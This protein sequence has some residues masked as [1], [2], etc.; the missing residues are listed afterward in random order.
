[1]AEDKAFVCPLVRVS[2]KGEPMITNTQAQELKHLTTTIHL[3]I[4]RE[5]GT[6]PDHAHGMAL[7]ALHEM[8]CS[9]VNGE[10]V[11]Q[12]GRW[13]FAAPIGFGK[14]S[15]VAAFLAAAYQLGLLGNGITMTL[16]ASR[17]EQLYDFEEALLDAGISQADVGKLVAVIHGIDK[18]VAKRPSDNDKKGAPILMV[19]HNRIRKVY[20]R[21]EQHLEK[22]LTY[23]LKCGDKARDFVLWDERAQ[24]TEVVHMPVKN[25]KEALDALCGKVEEQP[26]LLDLCTWLRACLNYINAE[27][28][29]MIAKSCDVISECDGLLTHMPQGD[30]QRF[31]NQIQACGLN[32]DNR[33]ALSQFVEM[34][35]FKSRVIPT[36]QAGIIAYHVVVPDCMTKCLVLDA[37][38]GVSELTPLDP[39][40]KDAEEHHPRLLDMKKWYGK[41]LADLKD[42]SDHE[43]QHWDTGAGKD[44]VSSDL[45]DYIAGKAVGGNLIL[46]VIEKV[47][48]YLAAGRNILIWTHKQDFAGNNLVDLLVEAL[49]LAGCDL[50]K[51][52]RDRF[53]KGHPERP[54]IVVSNY[55]QHDANNS[56]TYCDVV[57]HLGIQERQ[58]SEI[59]AAICGQLHS[60]GSRLTH[61]QIKAVRVSEKAATFQQ[62]TGRGQCRV[63]VNGKS[64]PQLSIVIFSQKRDKGL[65]EKIQAAFSRSQWE[66]WKTVYVKEDDGVIVRWMKTVEEHLSK[67]TKDKVSSRS[68]RQTLKASHVAPRTWAVIIKRVSEASTTWKLEGQSLLKQNAKAFGFLGEAA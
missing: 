55:G 41:T 50:T 23:F 52:V 58:D 2:R 31:Y 8:L 34:L 36:Q 53:S 46:E 35:R 66:K 17:V 29:R 33:K 60:L 43:I 26:A 61:A 6:I 48:T 16:T 7:E 21:E 19:A 13:A 32:R 56:W 24:R 18:K 3:Q 64:L 63:T 12:H 57:I 30:H 38:Y 39:S 10:D 9:M 40:I 25:F 11:S 67:E 42:C 22:D 68:L 45:Q 65:K 37:S 59:A 28:A 27:N 5:H 20:R 14:S 44:K 4:L 15:G 62:S 47:K 49:R 54:Q 1:M 51:M